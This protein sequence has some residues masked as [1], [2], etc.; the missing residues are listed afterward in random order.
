[1][2]YSSLFT[3]P[4][5][6]PINRA[7]GK[8]KSEEYLAKNPAATYPSLPSIAALYQ[9]L[10][11]IRLQKQSICK[12]IPT[13]H[14]YPATLFLQMGKKKTR[15]RAFYCYCPYIIERICSWLKPVISIMVVSSMPFANI[16]FAIS[17]PFRFIPFSIP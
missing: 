16:F 17:S 4:S 10:F 2:K 9:P 3:H 11:R 5:Q 12:A 1:M 13:F 14:H 8:V 15:T 7:F 6:T